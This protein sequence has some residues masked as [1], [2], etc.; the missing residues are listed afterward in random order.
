M[1]IGRS[2]PSDGAMPG[3]ARTMY[4]VDPASGDGGVQWVRANARDN[5]VTARDI[6]EHKYS[7][8]AMEVPY[9]GDPYAPDLVTGYWTD[10]RR[11]V[12]Q[13]LTR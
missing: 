1:N 13:H 3:I 10:V 12:L 2:A 6:D 8:L 9:H 5:A 7:E 4:I 11:V